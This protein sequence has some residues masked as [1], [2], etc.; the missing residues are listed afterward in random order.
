MSIKHDAFQMGDSDYREE[1]LF[2]VWGL[3]A[4]FNL[5]Q[6]V[7]LGLEAR[8]TF[9]NL[10][11]DSHYRNTES[12]NEKTLQN[13]SLSATFNVYL[14]GANR[15][16]SH[17]EEALNAKYGGGL[18]GLV[19]V[20]DPG[21]A[22]INFSHN[23]RFHDQ[24]FLGT[25][26]GVDFSPVL[27]ARAFYY[28][29]TQ[30][31]SKFSLK[32]GDKIQ[33]YG[34]NFI[35]RLNYLR[36]LTPYLSLGGGY[37]RVS[38]NYVDRD[39]THNAE[40]G[41]FALAGAGLEMPIHRY[42]SLFANMNAMLCENEN[43]GLDQAYRP[44]QVRA[45]MMYQLGLRF[46]LG[47]SAQN[48]QQLYTDYA[49]SEVARLRVR[50]LEEQKAFREADRKKTAQLLRFYDDRIA[51]L[52]SQLVVPMQA[53]DSL[54]TLRLQEERALL[55]DSKSKMLLILDPDVRQA[56]EAAA[57]SLASDS[58]GRKSA[59]QTKKRNTVVLTAAQ[60]N[61]IIDRVVNDS[62][63]STAASS[64]T[65]VTLSD[66]DK[67]LLFALVNNGHSLVPHTPTS[68]AVSDRVNQGA[69]AFGIAPEELEVLRKR[70]EQLEKEVL[71]TKRSAKNR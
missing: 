17:L 42:F 65:P 27:G 45:N 25:A 44:S 29:S 49:Q 31:P 26:A 50:D 20:V 32:L 7:T 23:S 15:S 6:R 10:D 70:I 48:A 14:G 34:A 71:K 43:P 55:S 54:N 21:M 46:R 30:T 11:E 8:N 57:D 9:F 47:K 69:A 33:L 38:D 36:G 13:W 68:T 60:L 39:G 18:K 51:Q 37:M 41:W 2:G 35:G 53:D 19:W 40:N 52:D 24:W 64:S 62:E 58:L 56:V 4:K 28:T 12:P 3:G 66:L 5:T 16:K 1:Q 59:M 61:A 22:Y 67:I 63:P